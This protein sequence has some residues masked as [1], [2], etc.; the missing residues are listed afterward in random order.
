VLILLGMLLL[1]LGPLAGPARADALPVF[2]PD[3]PDAAAYGAAEGYPVHLIGP[4][5][6]QRFLVGAFSHADRLLPHRDVP[7]A[8]APVPFARSRQELV[9]TYKYRGATHSLADY[10]ERNPATGLLIIR[11]RTIMFEH[12]QYGR[13]DR[14][15][16]VSQS[17]AKTITGML[18]GIAVDEGAIRS[19]DDL[20]ETYVPGLRGSQIGATSIR[21]LLHMASGIA[22]TE[23]YDG[24]DDSAR[25]TRLLWQRNG[26]GP[27]AAVRRFNTRAAPPEA[28][29][30]YAGINSEVLGLVLTAATG[31]HPADYLASRI[32]RRIGTEAAAD[33]SVDTSGQEATMCCFSA[34]LRDWARLG[35]LLAHDGAWDGQQVIPRQWVL[36]ATTAAASGPLAPRIATP[37]YGYGYQTWLFPNFPALG[38]RRQFALLGIHGQAIFVDPQSKLVLVH[39]A[40]RTRPTV[41]PAGNELPALWAALLRQQAR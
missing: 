37:F 18:I 31:M 23:T 14:D 9:L 28:E 26:P 7:A 34:V 4:Q 11:D 25:L 40:V 12:Y 2:S 1:L 19:V 33:W 22:F 6:D 15:R 16:M 20:A 17:M 38:P 35:E 13:T 36:D 8:P 21:A 10:L 41:D 24:H 32:W 29:F 27:V 3:G 39:T 30:H 5:R